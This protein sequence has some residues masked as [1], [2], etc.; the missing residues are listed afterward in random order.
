MNLL[1]DKWALIY[2]ANDFDE[3]E[4]LFATLKAAGAKAGCVVEEP[5]WIEVARRSQSKE[6]EN[7]IKAQIEGPK[8]FVG[9]VVLL[10][11]TTYYA[12]VKRTLDKTG[13]VS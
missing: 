12:H 10:P 8:Q 4:H 6:W 5:H 3:A 1:K 7:E 11:R 2:D 9:A 13:M